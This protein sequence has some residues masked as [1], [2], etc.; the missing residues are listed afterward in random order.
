MRVCVCGRVSLCIYL[1]IFI[2][3][4]LS[5][6]TDGIIRSLNPEF[7]DVDKKTAVT[8]GFVWSQLLFTP[9]SFSSFFHLF[10]ITLEEYYRI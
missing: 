1:Q 7:V 6:N 4:L 2:I 9:I 10:S 8:F 5:Q 3:L